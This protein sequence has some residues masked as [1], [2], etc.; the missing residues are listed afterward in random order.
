MRLHSSSPVALTLTNQI[1]SFPAPNDQVFPA[2]LIKK[3]QLPTDTNPQIIRNLLR[4]LNKEEKFKKFDD[5]R[6]GRVLNNL[7]LQI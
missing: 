3:F 1:S 4:E 7:L 6:K 2:I 5:E